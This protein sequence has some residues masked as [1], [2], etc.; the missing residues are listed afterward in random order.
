MGP[1]PPQRRRRGHAKIGQGQRGRMSKSHQATGLVS[2][3][4]RLI[5][6]GGM[7][8]IMQ[9][10]LLRSVNLLHPPP[11]LRSSCLSAM[12]EG[13]GATVI[14]VGPPSA[15]CGS[16]R[17]TPR[18]RPEAKPRTSP[19][20]YRCSSAFRSMP[21]IH[22]STGTKKWIALSRPPPSTNGRRPNGPIDHR[23]SRETE[24][25]ARKVARSCP[26]THTPKP[27][28]PTVPLAIRPS[29]EN[30]DAT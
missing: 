1:P 15:P 12:G 30:G 23:P 9:L 5:V 24:D 26:R 18:R 14:G 8:M 20:F 7:A 17:P 13:G 3:S 28:G 10:I 21:D 11:H 25:F 29:H 19:L 22:P 16:A 27:N 2:S 4:H 6:G